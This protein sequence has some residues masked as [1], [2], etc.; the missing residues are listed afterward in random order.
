MRRILVTGAATWT[1]GR[2]IQ[3]LE[4][5]AGFHVLAVDEIVLIMVCLVYAFAD[6]IFP[7]G[8]VLWALY[9][10]YV[11]DHTLFALRVARTT[12]LKKIAVDP[13]DITPTISLGITI[14]HSVAMSLPIL[15]EAAS[16]G[17]GRRLLGLA[18]A[19]TCAAG[20][21]AVDNLGNESTNA[22]VLVA[23]T[24]VEVG[25]DVPAASSS[26][27]SSSTRYPPATAACVTPTPWIPPPTTTRSN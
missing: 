20:V 3:R 4:R 26:R 25:L 2:L 24:V 6:A 12:Y 9:A 21:H 18:P 22:G 23:T 11:L 7:A 10:A 14:D 17:L 27:S 15:S 5:R 19:T 1:G 13:A 16:T 8:A